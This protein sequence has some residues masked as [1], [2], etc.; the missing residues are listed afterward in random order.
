MSPDQLQKPKIILASGSPRR[1]EL[2]TAAGWQFEVIV[3]SESAESGVHD[4]E[5]PA[6]LVARLAFQKAR[7]VAARIDAGLVI[8]CDTVAECC[9]QVLGKPRDAQHARQMLEVL[10]G[11]EHH[12][13]SGLCL[14]LVPD[15]KVDTQVEVTRLVMDPVS[16]DLLQSYLETGDWQG[17]AGAFGYQDGYDWLRIVGGS[18]SNVVGLPMELLAEMTERILTAHSRRA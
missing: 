16:D 4:G 6:E 17:K 14:W 9:G 5:S 11:N 7:D 13:L 10:R 12:V 2:L 3:P 18:E 8:A 15:N 1:R